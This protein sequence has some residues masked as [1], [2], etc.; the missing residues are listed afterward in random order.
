MSRSAAQV[1]SAPVAFSAIGLRGG[2]HALTD[3]RQARERHLGLAEAGVTEPPRQR[4]RAPHDRG[5]R[6]RGVVLGAGAA[7]LG[8]VGSEQRGAQLLVERVV[9]PAAREGNRERTDVERGVVARGAFEVEDAQTVRR[10]EDVVRTPVARAH[11]HPVGCR[12]EPRCDVEQ[13]LADG[14]WRAELRQT[15]AQL[16]DRE[17]AGVAEGSV[18]L[19][20]ARRAPPREHGK[21]ACVFEE[22]VTRVHGIVAEQHIGE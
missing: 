17:V 7:V 15:F 19:V 5:L 16:D 18:V 12:L 4:P 3:G 6:D 14:G 8:G 1:R 2:A 13:R 11:H 9:T 22:A 20:D 21:E 10:D